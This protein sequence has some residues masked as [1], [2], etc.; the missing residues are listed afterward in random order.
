[1]SRPSSFLFTLAM[2]AT[3]SAAAELPGED[4]VRRTLAE[5]ERL[6]DRGDLSFVDGFAKDAVILGPATPDLVGFDAIRAAYTNLMKQAS[7]EAH[8]STAEVVAVGDFAY[9][10]G[11]YSL[12]IGD[13]ASGKVLLD[14]KNR[15]LHI[16]KRQADG[17]WKTWRMMVNSAE[18]AVR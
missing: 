16:F 14:A 1:M 15:H 6:I 9:E 4:A 2:A 8:F 11:A 7:L 17:T 12:R 5:T 13:R 10:R 18:P 3:L